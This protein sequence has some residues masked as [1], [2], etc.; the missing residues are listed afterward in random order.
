MFGWIQW[1]DQIRKAV[2]V[3]MADVAALKTL[4]LEVK[5]GVEGMKATVISETAEL[6]V[7]AEAQSIKASNLIAKIEE[8]TAALAAGE[9]VDLSEVSAIAEDLKAGVASA[10]GSIIAISD[11]VADVPFPEL[12]ADEPA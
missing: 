1:I 8:L 11:A 3:I 7:L 12:P 2:G 6:K 5:D 4:L 9:N 10:T